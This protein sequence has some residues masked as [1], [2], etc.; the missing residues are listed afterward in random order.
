MPARARVALARG[1]T[2]DRSLGV[3][4]AAAFKRRQELCLY[5][6]ELE[7]DGIRVT[8]RWLG[9]SAK[10]QGDDLNLGD[11]AAD[12]A[13][14]DFEDVCAADLCLAFTEPGDAADRGR[15]GRH[16]ELGIAIGLGR[17]VATVGPI[18]HV[19]H[20]LPGVSNHSDWDAAH[21]WL[22]A[23]LVPARSAA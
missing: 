20:R 14:M 11:R 18:E 16:A 15:G 2:E 23:L 7:A 17:S 8:S 5:A 13:Q 21:A 4:F 22:L 9:G 10:L 6:A 1:S 3:Y 12:L 19:F